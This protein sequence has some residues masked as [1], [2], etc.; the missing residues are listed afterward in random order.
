M[1]R[2]LIN[3]IQFLRAISV[4]LVFFYHLKLNFFEYGFIGVDIFFV[5]SGYVITSSIY[6]EYYETKKFDFLNFYKKRFKR[7]YPVFLFIFSFSLIL[8]IFFQPLELFLNNFKVYIFAIFGASNL[9]YLFSTKDYFDTVFDDPFA[10]SWSLG[11][12]EQ[13]YLLFP[14]FFVLTLNFFK[15]IDRN[16]LFI[17]GIIIIGVISTYFFSDNSKLVFYSPIFRFWQ[18]LMGSLTFLITIKGNKKNLLISILAFVLLVTFIINGEDLNNI[19]LIFICSILT[20]FFIFFYKGNKFGKILFENKFLIFIGNISY[21]FYLWH[22]PVVYFYN[23]YFV[24]SF[25]KIPLLFFIVLILS[26]LSFFYVEN[27]FR[28]KKFNLFFNKYY[29][30]LT[31]FLFILII[32]ITS[33]FIFKKSYNSKIKN[34][35]KTLIYNLNYL[36]NI[37]N[38]SERAIFYKINIEGNQIYRFCTEKSEEY[39]LNKIKL[40][41]ECLKQG[42]KAKRLFYVEGDSHTASF[43]PMLNSMKF[44]DAIYYEHKSNSLDKIDYEKINS[45]TNFY[46][47]IIFTTDI[48]NIHDLNIIKNVSNNFNNKVKVLI[49]GPIPNITNDIDPLKCFIKSINCSFKTSVDIEKRNLNEYFKVVEKILHNQNTFSFYNP[50]KIICPKNKCFVYNLKNDLLTFRDFD[51]LTIEGSLLMKKDFEIYYN[52]NYK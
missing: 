36:E 37:K 44:D 34:G 5:I 2:K 18:F 10:H 26:S 29:L 30:F 52:M 8:V 23:L 46:D 17:S 9:Y 51:H 43:I 47:E 6:S 31:S 7:I 1:N 45:L 28:K 49:L 27:K 14:I 42:K 38:Y 40:R 22:L 12:E 19:T 20:C 11:V 13:F 33:Y 21:S 25:F 15:K 35:I 39:H 32:L 50:Y 16:I 48:D 3:H 4:L 24:D 41:I